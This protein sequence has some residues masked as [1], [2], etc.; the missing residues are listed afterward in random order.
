M[1][2]ELV[3]ADGLAQLCETF[4]GLRDKVI[5]WNETFESNVFYNNL[6]DGGV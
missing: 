5:K 4:D 3:Y 6:N 1:L 2:R